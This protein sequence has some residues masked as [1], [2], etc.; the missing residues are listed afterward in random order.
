M[1]KILLI[2]CI[3]IMSM[4]SNAQNGGQANENNVI[5]L[6]FVSYS[7]YHTTV[8]ITN[9]QSIPVDIELKSGNLSVTESFP[10]F[11]IK[12]M[13]LVGLKGSNVKIQAKPLNGIDGNI[14]VVELFLNIT[15]L[16]VKFGEI[17]FKLTSSKD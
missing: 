1:K 6:E 7:N 10:A 13:T 15:Y 5:K 3:A 2:T 12:F 14:G 11:G 8:R 17:K 9:K 16:P 4:M